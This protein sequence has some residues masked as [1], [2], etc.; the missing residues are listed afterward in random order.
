MQL[1]FRQIRETVCSRWSRD[2][3]PHW[4]ESMLLSGLTTALCSIGL[5]VLGAWE[6]V[7]RVTYTG[8]FLVRDRLH[9]VDWDERIAVIAIDE[10]SLAT[11][12]A[13]PWSRD[14]YTHLLDQLI[15]V[16]PAAIGFGIFM[17]E[18]TP[19]DSRLAESIR[20]NSN[21][22]LAVGNDPL[23]N[24]IQV[25]PSL[26]GP[27]QG[28]V[29]L[30]HVKHT[31]DTDGLSRQAFLYETY[32]TQIASSFAIAVTEAYQTS[33][34]NLITAE[35]ISVPTINP[36]FW[37]H[38]NEFDQSS[39]L[40]INWPGATRLQASE[41]HSVNQ[42]T[43]LSFAEVMD[44]DNH[45]I[46][47][48]LQNKIV[49][50]GYT[51]VGT[52]SNTEHA[53]RTPFEQQ[54]PTA[55]VYLHAAVIDNLLNDRFL[56]R[57]PLGYTLAGIVLISLGGSLALK[58]LK[59]GGRLL[60]IVGLIPLWFTIAYGSFLL[61]LWLPVAA[62]IGTSL[63]AL[64]VSQFAEQRERQTLMDLFA[65]NL[66]PEMANFIWRHK[67]ELLT[68]GKIR[69][70]NL[71]ATILFADIRGFSSISEKLPSDILL[72]WLNR[73]FEVMTDCIMAHGGVVDK[74]IGDSLMAAFGALVTQTEETA[75]GHTAIAAVHASL[76]MMEQLGNLNQEF[77]AKG[78]PTV[79]FGIGIHTGPLVGGTVGSRHRVNYSLFG[80]T[81]NVASR[82]QEMT[83]T[84]TQGTEYPILLSK[85]TYEYVLNHFEMREKGQM[86]L[87]GRTEETTVYTPLD[88][89]SPQQE[90]LTTP[91]S[92]QLQ[93]SMPSLPQAT[94]PMNHH[95]S[96]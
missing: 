93:S 17:S 21:V 12:G 95:S 61:G 92:N 18:S 90:P 57:L 31:P 20:F 78:W 13:Y 5:L 2:R 94:L 35:S 82:L 52:V 59:M 15:T 45:D 51:A 7:E 55:N 23:G 50:I 91:T 87:R 89:I 73:Y 75:I 9:P 84:V 72:P 10:A 11:Y 81:V 77:A 34:E 64:M 62:P 56:H 33:L 25:A 63:L 65:I 71:T 96:S 83:K 68:A 74:Y 47:T 29:R 53:I 66:S 86:V 24:P 37:T 43:T 26:L 16:Q 48:Q 88:E 30:G 38:P 36:V 27:T 54:I 60:V 49:L 19:E 76:S 39:P 85:A 58:P 6:P 3:A 69:A 80:D 8:L 22:V 4:A 70:Q 40:W 14:Q 46:V 41:S 79:K 44:P 32:G 42:L 1:N 28:F 67:R